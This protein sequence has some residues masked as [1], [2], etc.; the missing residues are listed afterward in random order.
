M[1]RGGKVAGCVS[2]KSRERL[3]AL[4]TFLSPCRPVSVRYCLYQLA[5]RGLHTST[6][7]QHYRSLK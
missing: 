7:K 5:L 6:A 3:D 2:M 1:A 4:R